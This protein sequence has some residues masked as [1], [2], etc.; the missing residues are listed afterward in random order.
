[1]DAGT[2]LDRR[3]ELAELYR[4]E[5][6]A[7][8]TLLP[9]AAAF[10]AATFQTR[11]VT[12]LALTLEFTA[13]C[14]AGF[15]QLYALRQ[16]VRAN[17]FSFPYGAGKFEDFARF[18]RGALYVPS[19]LIVAYWAITRLIW[20]FD[21]GYAEAIVVVALS[22]GRALL[23]LEWKRRLMASSP[24]PSERLRDAYRVRRSLTLNSAFIV[25]VLGIGLA[26]EEDGLLGLGERADAIMALLIVW[27]MI[28]D[29]AKT[30]VR[31][32]NALVDRP[33][34]RAQREALE[35][36]LAAHAGECGGVQ[37]VYTRASGHERFVDIDLRFADDCSLAAA[38]QVGARIRAELEE[39]LGDTH[40]RLYVAAGEAGS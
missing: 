1:M 8:W 37:G 18:L 24:E 3:R 20:P 16:A 35:R 29:G 38:E 34:P 22:L 15:F 23:L 7:T 6:V 26:L 5:R 30:A 12:V 11:S 33:L 14:V 13:S 19:A 17:A 9:V 10:A 40:V 27:Y 2:E 25:V 32:F 28:Q 4:L 21:V 36:V 31:H 39:A